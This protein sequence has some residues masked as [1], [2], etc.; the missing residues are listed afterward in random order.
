MKYLILFSQF[1]AIAVSTITIS[2][3]DDDGQ[4]R[5]EKYGGDDGKYRPDGNDGRYIHD[6]NDQGNNDAF[7]RQGRLSASAQT[8]LF[9]NQFDNQFTKRFQ[10]KVEING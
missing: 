10:P 6:Y 5:P 4:Y 1:F 9:G 7:G 3:A 8:S 2:S